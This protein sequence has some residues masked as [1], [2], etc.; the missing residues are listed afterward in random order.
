MNIS[1]DVE[2][3]HGNEV[4]LKQKGLENFILLVLGMSD[5]KLP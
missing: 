2:M 4:D 3:Q 5:R 1:D